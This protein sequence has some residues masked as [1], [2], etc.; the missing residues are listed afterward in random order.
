MCICKVYNA[1]MLLCV[2]V[3]VCISYVQKLFQGFQWILTHQFNS[4]MLTS[5]NQGEIV[6]ISDLGA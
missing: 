4:R 1:C 2:Y 5:S 6:R 3:Y